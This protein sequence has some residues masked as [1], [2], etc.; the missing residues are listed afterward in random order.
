MQHER[1]MTTLEL[2]AVLAIVALVAGVTV[3]ASFAWIRQQAS[4]S[5]VYHVQALLQS[6]RAEAAVRN[7][8]CRFVIDGSA[9]TIQVIALNDPA[10]SS[11]DVLLSSLLLSRAVR[12]ERPGG[13]DPITLRQLAGSRYEATFEADGTVSAGAGGQIVLW[14]GQTYH[15]VTLYGAGGVR[16]ERWR[17]GAWTLGV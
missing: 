3:T 7:R 16:V 14:G 12:F 4:Q 6:T 1:G 17:G 13:G 2:L 9:R 11:D 5:A 10:V 8:P 15:R